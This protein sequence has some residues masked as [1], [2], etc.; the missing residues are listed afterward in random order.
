MA[1]RVETD[2]EIMTVQPAGRLSVDTAPG[3]RSVL[4]KAVAEGPVAIIISL[5]DVALADKSCLTLFPAIAEHAAEESEVS[6]LLCAANGALA[7]SLHAMGLDASVPLYPTAESAWQFAHQQPATRAA[8]RLV[9]TAEAPTLARSFVDESCEQW[10]VSPEVTEA[11]RLISTELVTNVVIHAHTAMRL[12][13]RRSRRHIHLAVVDEEPRPAT[14]RR[15]ASPQSPTGRG[16]IFVEA[17]SSAW[18]CTPTATGK[19]TWA[20]VTCQP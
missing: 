20:T 11:L 17:F 16:L 2:G 19:S 15:P 3:L 1:C 12:I 14:L 8:L 7:E 4:Y 18:G 9:S 6:V 5:A 10:H 13:L